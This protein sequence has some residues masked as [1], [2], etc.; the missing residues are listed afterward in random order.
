MRRSPAGAAAVVLGALLSLALAGCLGGT[1]SATP[2]GSLD[3]GPTPTVTVYTPGTSGWIEGFVVTLNRATATLDAK[4]GPVDVILTFENTGT[5]DATPDSPIQLT[6]G[7]ATFDVPHEVDMPD[8]AAGGFAE[9]RLEFQVLGQASIDDGVLQIGRISDHDI[10]LPLVPDP[11]R[12]VTLQ[13]VET[14]IAGA[15][16]GGSFRTT[17]HHVEIRWDLPDYHD[18][19]PL[20]T[21]ALTITYDVTNLGGFAGGAPFTAD[22][23]QLRLP[24][25]TLLSPRQDGHSQTIV[26]IGAGKTA[27]GILSRF[28]IPNGT[29]GRLALVVT[30]GTTAKALPFTIGP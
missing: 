5:D 14:D 4:G 27:N 21:E 19:L 20:G 29:T 8:I 13:P 1:P 26:L 17:L 3:V 28:E 23:V 6:S 2:V 30:A 15:G 9:V 25:G 12:T 10:A 18:E 11:A 16:R 24:D 7:A 22:N